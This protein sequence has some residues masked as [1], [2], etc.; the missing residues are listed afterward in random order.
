M[1]QFSGGAALSVFCL[2]LRNLPSGPWDLAGAGAGPPGLCGTRGRPSGELAD[3]NAPGWSRESALT[4]A[5]GITPNRCLL[6]AAS[7]AVQPGANAVKRAIP[8][9]LGRPLG[10]FY[11][12]QPPVSRFPFIGAATTS[13]ARLDSSCVV[14]PSKTN[15][16]TKSRWAPGP[17]ESS[18]VGAALS[19]QRLPNRQH[20]PKHRDIRWLRAKALLGSFRQY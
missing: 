4:D 13:L 9:R 5:G 20:S 6:R 17:V 14:L 8:S 12:S 18:G 15:Q 16:A 11:L 7:G 2:A 1:A 3:E 19:P 10:P